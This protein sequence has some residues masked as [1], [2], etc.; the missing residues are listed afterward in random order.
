MNE[1][2]QKASLRRLSPTARVSIA[3]VLGG[4]TGAV[5]GPRVGGV[6]EAG[7]AVIGLIKMLA[8][9]L[10]LFAVLDAF[11]RTTIRA[12]SGLIMVGISGV[13]AALAVVIGLTLANTLQP[14]RFLA[15]PTGMPPSQGAVAGVRTVRFLDDL[16]GLL[17]TNLVEPFRTNAVV[18]VVV[19]AVLAG[20]ALRRYKNE[21]VAAGGRE[22]L[23]IQG[24]V[25]G[26]LRTLE[27]MLG[28]VVALLPVAVFAVMAQ[29]VGTQGLAALRGLA[30]YLGVVILGLAIHVLL[31]Y[32]S[33]VV[34]V[35]RVPLRAFWGAVRAPLAC[36]AGS[37]SSLATLPVTLRSL[38]A[39]GVSDG[40]AR[41]AACVATNL[42]NDGILLYEAMAALIVAQ[43]FGIPLTLGQQLMVAAT[44]VLASVGI[45]GV[46]EAGLISLSVVLASAKLPLELLPLLLSVDW[47]LGRC[48]AMTNVVGDIL[49]A[50]VLDR[51]DGSL[52]VEASTEPIPYVDEPS[53]VGALA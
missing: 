48:R 34:F 43:A 44:C 28:W 49:G 11:L 36:A 12:R 7:K 21:Q 6:G 3:M 25:A 37:S 38:K 20:A 47:V 5:L 35:A 1:P 17:P 41:M 51:L 29:T 42:N 30:A 15:V 27:L 13:N 26:A 46:P 33:W 32:Q 18:P 19:L 2:Q 22:Y 24:F 16:L 14:G 31:V 45:A 39:M 8:T 10:I 52:S 9:P 50:V 40:S 23:A 53:A 4:L